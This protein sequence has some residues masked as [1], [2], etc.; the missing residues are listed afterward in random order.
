MYRYIFL[1]IILLNISCKEK[2]KDLIITNKENQNLFT[3]LPDSITGINFLNELIENTYMNGLFYEY[4]YNGGGVAVTDFNNDGKVDIYFVNSLK[5][6][7]LY[8]NRGN[9]RFEDVTKIANAQGGYGFGTGVTLVD[10]NNDGLMDIYYSKSGKF[11]DPNKRK[12]ELLVNLGIDNK[13]IPK[14]ENRAEQY[15]LDFSGFSTQ[16]A[17]FDYDRDGDLDMFLINHGI[18]LYDDREI[19]QLKDKPSNFRG[20][21]LFRNDNGKFED[22]TNSAGIINTMLGFCLGISIGD[23]NNDNWPDIYVSNDFSERDHLYINNKNGT[24]N[25]V[26]LTSFG[27]IP[28]FSMGNDIADFNNDGLYDIIALDMMAED[29]YTQKTSMSGMNPEEFYLHVDLGLHHQYMYNTLQMNRGVSAKNSNPMFSD[30]AQITGVSSTDW[31]WGPLIFDMDNNGTKDLFISNGIKRDFRNNDFIR[32]RKKK[33]A[34]VIENQSIET[35]SY[36][37]DMLSKM[38][39]RRKKN[40]FYLNNGNLDFKKLVINQPKTNS[41]GA[42]YADFDN[43]GDLDLVVNNSSSKSFIYRNNG[44]ENNF[45]KVRLKGSEK[46]VDAIGSRVILY[47]GDRQ[48]FLDKYFTRGFQSAMADDLIFGLGK[49]QQADSLK[50]IWPDGTSQSIKEINA[51]QTIDVKYNPQ[52]ENEDLLIKDKNE[53]LFADIIQKTGV[54]FLHNENDFDDFKIETLLPHR[55]SRLG[56][57]LAVADVNGD[58]LDDFFIG[59]ASGQSSILYIQ[60]TKGNFIKKDSDFSAEKSQE[61]VGA[62]FFDVDNDGDK[63]LYVVSGGTEMKPYDNYYLDRLYENKGDGHFVNNTKSLPKVNNSGLNVSAADFDK[64]GD[65]D[66]FVG[67]RVLPGKYGRYTKSFLLENRSNQGKILFEDVTG[68]IFPQ[69]EKHTMVVDS[70]WVDLDGDGTQELIIANEWGPVEIYE[71]RNKKF[72]NLTWDYNLSDQIGWWSKLEITDVDNDGDMDIIAGN[73]GQNYKYK[74]SDDMPFFMYVNDFDNNGIDDIVLGYKQDTAVFPVRGRQCSSGQ[75]PFI[76]KK[77]KTYDEFGRADINTIYGEQ[78]KN[79]IKYRANNFKTTLFEND[80]GKFT[81]EALDVMTQLSSV[82][83]I[84]AEDFNG[85]GHIDLLLLG[86]LNTSEVETP[87]ND[88]SYGTLLLGKPDGNF[89]YISNNQINLWANGDIKNAR[90]I[91]IAGKRAVIIAK[92]NDSVSILSLPHLSP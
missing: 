22:V 91:T 42:A 32:Y 24:F 89:S 36:V 14:F 43:D 44:T 26:S 55:M 81:A 82:N 51:N 71:Y 75:M 33:Q 68:K 27:H 35:V 37:N 54:D 85:D 90:L 50:I 62:L 76:K 59:G 5:D 45:V 52:N 57:A 61:D 6:N 69:M 86:N 21:R 66:L 20:E 10:I 13:G 78:L 28:N 40:Y 87:R 70:K 29:N 65:I 84:I 2:D 79:A 9:M 88:A 60:T 31:S 77:F 83:E 41:N 64:D 30:V 12:N 67:G 48:Q 8:L 63:D 39:K 74:A 58:N 49:L 38:P 7:N 16:A 18:E 73:L 11:S 4:Y 56:P 46:N 53:Y 92:N 19:T 72:E 17:F 15:Q 80:N 25:E 34:E 1:L 23:L 3:A 47:T